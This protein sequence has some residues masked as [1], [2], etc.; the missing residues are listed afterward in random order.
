[1]IGDAG[2]QWSFCPT[3]VRKDV[4]DGYESPAMQSA[5]PGLFQLWLT[6][7][8][9]S[10]DRRLW[11]PECLTS[12]RIQSI[13]SVRWMEIPENKEA[14]MSNRCKIS[15]LLPALF[16]SALAGGL[17]AMAADDA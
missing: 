5:L 1:M 14:K 6:L 12:S 8:K 10:F 2:G 13:A 17:L 7:F 16:S 15:W 9:F 11:A 4:F 3:F